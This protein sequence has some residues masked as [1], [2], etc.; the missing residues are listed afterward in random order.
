MAQS[1]YIEDMATA[2]AFTKITDNLYM[3]SQRAIKESGVNTPKPFFTIYVSTAK[4]VRPPKS[5]TGVFESMWIRMEDFPWDY[6]S[7]LVTVKKLV[8]V[9]GVIA[10][11]VKSGHKVLIFCRMGMN[12]SG[13]IT[14]LTLMHMGWKLNAALKKIRERHHCTICNESFVNA[15]R[16]IEKT[17]FRR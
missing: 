9:T 12:R 7:D 17:Y 6:E 10:T 8:E 4:D 11:L 16:F 3:G 13:F 2:P 15:L 5:L 1:C 14:A